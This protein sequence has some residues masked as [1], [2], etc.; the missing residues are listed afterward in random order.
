MKVKEVYELT[1]QIIY[2][3]PTSTIWD[4]YLVGN[5]NRLL[6]ELFRENNMCRVSKGLEKLEHPQ[7]IPSQNY[8]NVEIELEEEYAR[9]VLPL[10]LAAQF[11]IDD[12]YNKYSIFHT[13]YMNARTI[14]QRIVGVSRL[15]GEI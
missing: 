14:Q 5:L 13:E 1:K 2:E 3:K 7:T 8:L 6:Q 12:D 15:E 9:N 4:K 11:E 10:G